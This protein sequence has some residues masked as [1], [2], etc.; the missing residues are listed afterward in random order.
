MIGQIR[1]LV[2]VFAIFAVI[3]PRV[4]QAQEEKPEP[5]PSLGYVLVPKAARRIKSTLT[6]EVKAPNVLADEWSVYVSQLPELPGQVEVKTSL[7]PQ[8]R[9]ARELSEEARP[10]LFTKIPSQGQDWRKN[11]KLRVDYEATLLERRLERREPGDPEPPTV[12]AL[13]PRV[14]RLM[15][16][17]GHQFDF[18]SPRFKAWLVENKLRRE[19]SESEI[20]FAR[21]AFL[22]VRHGFTHDEGDDVEHMASKVCELGKSDYAGLTAVFVAALRAN[23]IPTRVLAGRMVLY[24]GKPSKGAWPHARTEF[25]ANG[26]GWVPA[27]PAGAIR[28]GRKTEGLEFFGNDSA[29][30]LTHHVDTDIVVDT[31][32]GSKTHEWLQTPAWWVIGSGNFE[33]STTKVEVVTESEE[34]NL[35]EVITRLN[36]RP[37]NSSTSAAT[38]KS[39][40]KKG[41]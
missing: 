24:G 16:S 1:F 26:L 8:G 27:D 20:D 12:P 32:F 37:S 34:L 35:T 21:K 29:E 11:V 28:S 10:I 25:Y 36:A 6:I 39:A 5:G 17:S 13:D 33:G 23:G 22:A 18:N 3:S 14:K 38:K 41:R 7:F 2:L 4:G 9:A 31:Y 30:L 15:L 40:T 19:P